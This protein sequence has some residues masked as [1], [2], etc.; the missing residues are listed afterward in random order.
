[1]ASIDD[2]GGGGGHKGPGVKKQQRKSTLVDMTPLVDLGFLLITF[3]IFTTTM[4][5]PAAMKM[6]VPKDPEPG[7]VPTEAKKD[8]V[9]TIV[10]GDKDKVCTYERDDPKTM[11]KTSYKQL[12]SVIMSK[13]KNSN[14]DYFMVLIKP[15]KEADYK[16]TVD[17]LDEMTI[18]DCKLFALVD[19]SPEEETIIKT[20]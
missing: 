9:L 19:A 4:S 20:K 12:R 1:M 18:N 2:S 10:I 8:D 6:F 16:H 13:K 14:L 7:Q 15:T 5:E 3:F 17:V 11:T